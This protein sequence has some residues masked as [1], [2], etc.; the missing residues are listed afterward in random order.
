MKQEPCI[1]TV[2]LPTAH[3]ILFCLV[4]TNIKPFVFY[5]DNVKAMNQ[6][7]QRIILEN[8][9]L[10]NKVVLGQLYNGQEL[11]TIGGKLLRV[12]IYR[13]VRPLLGYSAI[14]P[15]IFISFHININ[16]LAF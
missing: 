16:D 2:N 5:T 10:K 12:F 7:S 15:S 1:Q 8:H 4:L 14:S 13:T 3:I 6:R 11:E 9:I